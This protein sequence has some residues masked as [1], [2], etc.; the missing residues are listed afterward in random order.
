M[1]KFLKSCLCKTAIFVGLILLGIFL[2]GCT[3]NQPKMPTGEMAVFEIENPENSM[4]QTYTIGEEVDQFE[5]WQ[6]WQKNKLSQAEWDAYMD[7]EA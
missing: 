2:F 3:E 4:W 7:S 1:K 5:A 6:K